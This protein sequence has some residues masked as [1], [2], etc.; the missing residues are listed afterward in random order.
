MHEK[1]L[2][3]KGLL[4]EYS[5]LSMIRMRL[6]WDQRTMMPRAGAAARA[7]QMATLEKVIHEKFID[8]TIGRLL[9]QLRPYEESL[10]YDSDEASLLRFTRHEY[11]KQTKI[12]TE[13]AS[14]MARARTMGESA[15]AQARAANNYGHFLPHLQANVDLKFK[16]IECLDEGQPTPYDIL[17]DDYEQ[18]MK[19]AEVQASFDELKKGLVPLI[20]AIVEKQESVSNACLHGDFPAE[21]QKALCHNIL[22]RLGARWDSW[23]LDPTVHPFASGSMQDIRITTRYLPNFVAGALFATMHEFGHGLYEHQVSPELAR[24]PLARGAS[25]GIHE[26]QSRLWENLVG[27]SRPFWQGMYAQVQAAFPEQFANVPV[28]EFYQAI[29]KVKP[30]YIRVEADEVT[31]PLHII[32]RFELEQEIIQG[33]I[34][35]KE[36]PEAWNARFKEYVGLDVP[37]DAQG[38]LQD[39]HW[40]YGAMGYFPTYA[41]GS[42][43]ACQ[44]WEKIVAEIGDIETQITQGEFSALREWLRVNIHQHGRKFT[45]SELLQRVVGSGIEVEPFLRYLRR[46]FGEQ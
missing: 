35:L 13:L 44:L 9:E 12:P 14:E 19:T 2:E 23:R 22:E 21:T 38:V 32:L 43:I 6:A 28:E 24:T 16:Y 17:L 26:S 30:S 18:G 33:K 11:E 41:L 3:L 8:P 7:E 25:L 42:I 15:W 37:N 27:R 40:S 10:P 46:K 39:V 45:P 20:G 36:L 34:A 1:Y 29:N 5:D 4:A 31:Y